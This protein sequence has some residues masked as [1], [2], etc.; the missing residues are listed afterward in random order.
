MWS[1]LCLDVVRYFLVY[2]L[3][4]TQGLELTN[5]FTNSCVLL[6]GYKVLFPILNTLHN[7]VIKVPDYCGLFLPEDKCFLSPY[8]VIPP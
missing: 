7:V 4:I 2:S 1:I 3:L 5:L 6:C 8:N